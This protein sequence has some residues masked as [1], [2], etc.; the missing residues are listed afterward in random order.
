MKEINRLINEARTGSSNSLKNYYT[1]Y[2]DEINK[3][4]REVAEANSDLSSYPEKER[5]Y[6]DAERGI[7]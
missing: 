1:K 5:K 2:Y 7:I 3:M 6:L 4:D